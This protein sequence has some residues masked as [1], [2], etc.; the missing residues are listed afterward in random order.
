MTFYANILLYLEIC[1]I[2]IFTL[3]GYQVYMFSGHVEFFGAVI[4]HD[5]RPTNVVLLG[6]ACCHSQCTCDVRWD[7]IAQFT[8]NGRMYNYKGLGQCVVSVL[9]FSRYVPLMFSQ[10]LSY[11]LNILHTLRN[12]ETESETSVNVHPTNI[13]MHIT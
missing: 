6:S 4:L 7:N 13:F 10:R 3:I 8:W 1:S 12:A 9:P 11:V 5:V 2:L